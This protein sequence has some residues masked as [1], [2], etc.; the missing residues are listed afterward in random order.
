MQSMLD[1]TGGPSVPRLPPPPLP[2]RWLLENPLPLVAFLIGAAVLAWFILQRLGRPRPAMFAALTSL[3]GAIA[4][5]TL[6]SLVQTPREALIVKTRTLVD[7][8]IQV[9]VPAVALMLDD[10]FTVRPWGIDRKATLGRISSDLGGEYRIKDYHINQAFAAI[11][12]PGIARTQV[13]IRA[14]PADQ[15]YNAP[16]GSW[17][18]LHWQKDSRDGAWRIVELECQQID[19]FSLESIRP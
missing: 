10:S 1:Q 16:I 6:A 12:G 17:W 15:M 5:Y 14:T 2:A 11:D 3:A 4:V 8:T 19:G 9:D 18:V 7:R 13:H